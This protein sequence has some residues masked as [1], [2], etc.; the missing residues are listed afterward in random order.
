MLWWVAP[1]R[2]VCGVTCSWWKWWSCVVCCS[3]DCFVVSWWIVPNKT[4]MCSVTGLWWKWWCLLSIRTYC[5]CSHFPHLGLV[6]FLAGV[7]HPDFLSALTFSEVSFLSSPALPRS[8]SLLPCS[9]ALPLGPI[10][11]PGGGRGGC[12]CL[13]PLP[14]PITHFGLAP[15]N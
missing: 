13:I 2:L 8:C 6:D 9:H 3:C 7:F 12:M 15:I 11:P 4:C 1:K 14:A 10:D 5:T